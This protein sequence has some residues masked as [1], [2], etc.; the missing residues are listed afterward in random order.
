M[1]FL[2][3][4]EQASKH[5]VQAHLGRPFPL[6]RTSIRRLST[7]TQGQLLDYYPP[8]SASILLPGLDQT[9][10][11]ARDLGEATAVAGVFV[12]LNLSPFFR[13][14]LFSLSLSAHILIVCIIIPILIHSEHS[15]FLSLSA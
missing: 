8:V 10:Q 2:P 7:R 1:L 5:G 15:S 13:L 3:A 9:R 11:T 4:S 6:F 14:L 12:D